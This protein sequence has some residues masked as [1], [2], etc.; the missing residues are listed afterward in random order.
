MFKLCVSISKP[1]FILYCGASDIKDR[2]FSLMDSCVQGCVPYKVKNF[3][4]LFS[5]TGLQHLCILSIVLT[6]ALLIIYSAL[7]G[8][9]FSHNM[10]Q[11]L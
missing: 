8:S 10:L 5:H 2:V 7:C 3:L 4:V 11:R 9:G 1:S 6:F